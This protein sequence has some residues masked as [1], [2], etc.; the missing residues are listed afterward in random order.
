MSK[1]F[2]C[3]VTFLILKLVEV[4]IDFEGLWR[5]CVTLEIAQFLDSVNCSVY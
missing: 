5:W 4:L 2:L 1:K 3:V